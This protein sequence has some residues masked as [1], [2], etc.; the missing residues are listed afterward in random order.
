[1]KFSDLATKALRTVGAIGQGVGLDDHLLTVAFEAANDMIDAWAAQR[2][3]VFQSLRRTMA[4]IANRGAPSNPYTIGTGGDFNIV[5]PLWID[6]AKILSTGTSPN[7][8]LPLHLYT[9]DEY[10]DLGLKTLGSSLATGLYYD[11]KFDTSGASQGLGQLFLYPVPNGGMALSLVLYIPTPMTEFA[12]KAATEYYFPP[13]YRE[14][15]RYQLAKRLAVELNRPL[16]PEAAQ[17]MIDTFAVIARPNVV[18]PTLCA[19]I[20][21]PGG[22]G[23]FNYRTGT[24]GGR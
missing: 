5:R 24:G 3:T 15:L 23:L 19:D 22:R 20:G 7:L 16:T 10:A 18:V 2:I 11:G 12:D 1:M 14:A 21:V 4:L 6:D 8:E 17:L 9:P 13:G